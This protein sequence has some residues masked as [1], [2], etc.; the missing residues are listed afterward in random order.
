M[1][2]RN[3]V[4]AASLV[5]I[6]AAPLGCVSIARVFGIHDAP[7]PSFSGAPTIPEVPRSVVD[8]PVSIP[9]DQVRTYLNSEVP[10]EIKKEG[11]DCCW[12]DF[13]KPLKG[14]HAWAQYLVRRDDFQVS[15]SGN[16]LNVKANLR[17]RI[18][19]RKKTGIFGDSTTRSCGYGNPFNAK[20]RKMSVGL[21]SSLTWAP[22]WHLRSTTQSIRPKPG[23]DCVLKIIGPFVKK[24][25]TGRIVQVLDR[26]IQKQAKA[27]IDA[28]VPSATNF[29]PIAEKAW[30]QLSDPVDLGDDI[31]LVVNPS[32]VAVAPIVV[33][34]GQIWTGLRIYA[35][36][37][38]TAGRRPSS[39]NRPLPALSTEEVGD[40]FYIAL[41][42]SV[43][44]D[45]ATEELAERLE[46]AD[47]GIRYPA[48]GDPHVRVKDVSVYT[49][50]PKVVVRAKLRGAFR[51]TI[52]LAG[53]PAFDFASQDLWVED[54]DYTIESKNL[55]VKFAD[56]L[57]HDGFRDQLRTRARW[58]AASELASARAD[59]QERLDRPLGSDAALSGT[60][61]SLSGLGA[62]ISP[63]QINALVQ[64]T[65]SLRIT[66]P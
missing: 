49:E 35:E 26:T 62:S 23:N 60:V 54:L 2:S 33:R 48:V 61:D 55:L 28:R 37:K 1:I 46:I 59:L 34:N 3:V 30:R 31:F 56:W 25:V 6:S 66:I 9:L 38:L 7:K 27:K 52:Y 14:D 64:A 65:G 39:G 50:G 24:N 57:N 20:A 32:E 4:L 41:E 19:F 8:V 22:Q 29:R 21:T 13:G 58:S 10:A 18:K 5:V 36:P 47:G 40:R 53:S 43:T 17:Y 12:D 45:R 15:G 16:R 63:G 44:Q 51:G 42:G 11:K